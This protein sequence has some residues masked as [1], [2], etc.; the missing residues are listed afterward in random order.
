MFGVI[1]GD[2]P[3][4][5]QNGPFVRRVQAVAQEPVT[6]VVNLLEGLIADGFRPESLL[7]PHPSHGR[8]IHARKTG[9]LDPGQTK[10]RR[11]CGIRDPDQGSPAV[12]GFFDPNLPTN[13]QRERRPAWDHRPELARKEP[14]YLGAFLQEV[15]DGIVGSVVRSPCQNQMTLDGGE[16]TKI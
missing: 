8:F 7:Y 4:L 16:R 12:V 2:G 13:L 9:L 1:I 14:F 11:P 10:V 5:V 15:G 3:S 6:H